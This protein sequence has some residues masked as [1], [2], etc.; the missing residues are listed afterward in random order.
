MSPRKIPES[1]LSKSLTTNAAL[2]RLISG[3]DAIERDFNPGKYSCDVAFV[4]LFMNL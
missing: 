3:I 1:V 2:D 4:F